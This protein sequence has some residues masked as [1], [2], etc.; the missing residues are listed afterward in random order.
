MN[1]NTAIVIES[2]VREAGWEKYAVTDQV[3]AYDFNQQRLLP[4]AVNSTNLDQKT[5][6]MLNGSIA[7]VYH[8]QVMAYDRNISQWVSAYSIMSG[9]DNHTYLPGKNM[10]R[11]GNETGSTAI[12]LW[13]VSDKLVVCREFIKAVVPT[14]YQ[15]P[16]SDWVAKGYRFVINYLLISK[17]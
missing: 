2:A 11:I 5:T 14:A 17:L 6:I 15:T 7:V 16:E 8:V 3:A 9:R 12:G 13:E 4:N 10:D 1:P